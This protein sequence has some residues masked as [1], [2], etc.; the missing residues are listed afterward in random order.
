L[1]DKRPATAGVSIP[2]CS[3]V[4]AKTFET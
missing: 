1:A 3:M 4:V 2:K